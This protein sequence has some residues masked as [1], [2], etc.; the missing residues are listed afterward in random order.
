M[1]I[2]GAGMGTGFFKKQAGVSAPTEPWG[3]PTAWFKADTGLVEWSGGPVV[4]GAAIKTWGNQGALGPDG[5]LLQVTSS[6]YCPVYKTGVFNGK[7]VLRFDGTGDV[8]TGGALLGLGYITAASGC[9]FVAFQNALSNTNSSTSYNND[10]AWCESTGN[11]G[12]WFR[13]GAPQ[14]TYCANY[15]GGDQKATC[16]GDYL[17]AQIVTWYHIGGYIYGQKNNTTDAGLGSG[18]ASGNTGGIGNLQVGRGYNVYYTSIDLAELIFYSSA[19]T[20]AN[21]KIT[22][23]YLAAKYGITLPY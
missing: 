16:T 10:A 19:V 5:D 2:V 20:E 14:V 12:V 8:L 6:D 18:V 3:T 11:A 21:R 7:D 13:N 4:D 23:Q 15:S 9:V 1:P 22:E 17:S